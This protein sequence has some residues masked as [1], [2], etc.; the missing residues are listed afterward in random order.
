MTLTYELLATGEHVAF[1]CKLC[2][3]VSTNTHDIARLYCGRCHLFH[4]AVRA[5]RQLAAEGGSHECAEWVTG[6]GYCAV[7]GASLRP[8][9]RVLPWPSGDD[10]EKLR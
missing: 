3:S 7:C 4:D 9:G 10:I 2:G 6:R 5:V 8:P 1:A